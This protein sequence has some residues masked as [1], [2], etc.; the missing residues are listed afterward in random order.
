MGTFSKDDYESGTKAALIGG[1]TTIFD[2]CTPGRG[3]TPLE[4]FDI[5]TQ[6]ASGKAA[7]DYA[8]HVGVAGFDENTPAQLREIVARGI[9]SFKIFLATKGRSELTM[10]SS[11]KRCESRRSS[12]SS[13]PLIV[14]IPRS[15]PA[16]KRI[17][18][19]VE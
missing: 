3:T 4:G 12:V 18:W 14:K 9:G 7:C 5:W 19:H 1:T 16:C 13:R 11:T 6:Q 15:S 10:R 8:F 2:M 17:S